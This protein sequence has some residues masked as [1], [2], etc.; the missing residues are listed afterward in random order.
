MHLYGF[1][2]NNSPS[3]PLGNMLFALLVELL[4]TVNIVFVHF[5]KETVRFYFAKSVDL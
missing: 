5:L 3:S 4:D 2:E 1:Q